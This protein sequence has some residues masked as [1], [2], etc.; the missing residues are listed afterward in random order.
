MVAVGQLVGKTKQHKKPH[1]TITIYLDL[2]FKAVL[3]DTF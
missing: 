3:Y 1:F 2:T